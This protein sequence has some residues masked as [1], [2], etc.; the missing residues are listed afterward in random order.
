[1]EHAVLKTLAHAGK[2]RLL[3]S[4]HDAL[5]VIG[6]D[7]LKRPGRGQLLGRIAQ[8]FLVGGTVVEAFARDFHQ[9]DHVRGVFADQPE[10]IVLAMTLQFLVADVQAQHHNQS[11]QFEQR[12]LENPGWEGDQCE[13]HCQFSARVRSSRGGSSP[14]SAGFLDGY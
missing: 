1:M 13:A 4:F 12:S 14:M 10:K 11:G 2:A 7:L 8:N 3:A 9:R 5:A 6:M